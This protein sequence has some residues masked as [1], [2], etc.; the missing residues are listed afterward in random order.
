MTKIYSNKFI[1]KV[2]TK[3]CFYFYLHCTGEE[4]SVMNL[5]CYVP[6]YVVSLVTGFR[7]NARTNSNAIGYCH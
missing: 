3:M 4:W 1:A 6:T 7:P 2:V 5:W